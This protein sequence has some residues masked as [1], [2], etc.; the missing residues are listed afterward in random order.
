MLTLLGAL[1]AIVALAVAL[2]CTDAERRRQE[3]IP[4]FGDEE[5]K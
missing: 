3:H 1:L 5:A 2:P 4:L